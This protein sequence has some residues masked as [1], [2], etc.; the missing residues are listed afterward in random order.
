MLKDPGETSCKLETRTCVD[1][2][3]K[4][5]K[6]HYKLELKLVKVYMLDKETLRK[7]THSFCSGENVVRKRIKPRHK[8]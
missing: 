4:V 6:S 1:D 5:Q 7:Y 2:H 8:V 3:R